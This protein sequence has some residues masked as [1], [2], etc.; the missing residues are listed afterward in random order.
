MRAT[1]NETFRHACP[2]ALC[3]QA[4]KDQQQSLKK[5]DSFCSAHKCKH[6]YVI[7][8]AGRRRNRPII[9]LCRRFRNARAKLGETVVKNRCLDTCYPEFGA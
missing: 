6:L 1:K 2:V 8:V 9:R 5:H 3:P 7:L 4:K